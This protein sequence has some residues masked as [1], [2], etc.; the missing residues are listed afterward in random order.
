[1]RS[2]LLLIAALFLTAASFRSLE[3]TPPVRASDRDAEV[4]YLPSG[5]ALRFLSLGF[6]NALADLLWFN[7]VSYFGKHF[8]SDKDYRWLEHMCGLVTDL[9]PRAQHVY[10]FCSTME[11]WEL[12]RPEV[13]EAL[14]TKGIAVLP[15]KWRL[16]YLRGFSRMYFLHD[17]AR[18]QEDFVRA[19]RLPDAPP[20]IAK[21]ASKKIANLD[22]PE[23]ALEFLIDI[24]KGTQDPNAR[25][26]LQHRIL[27]TRYEID[28]QRIETA[29]AEFHAHKGRYPRDMAEL[30]SEVP[31]RD[32]WGGAYQV[33]SVQGKVS[34]S[35]NQKRLTKKGA[36]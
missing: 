4:L 18:A 31:Q 20:F 23:A 12:N 29:V 7:T 35:S 25:R 9:D 36:P 34:S 27:Q 2:I 30:G 10:E 5:K 3:S 6:Q 14:L 22:S 28:L 8:R 11:A 32:P 13:A 19:A 1:M 17:E 26:A 24:Y 16:L 15:D 33:D 21:L